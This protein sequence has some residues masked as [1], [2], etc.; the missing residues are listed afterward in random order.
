MK[1]NR[2]V[3]PKKS[4]PGFVYVR[5]WQTA[6]TINQDF[7]NFGP[8]DMGEYLIQ[9][10]QKTDKDLSTLI[11]ISR[12]ALFFLKGDRHK[13]LRK[14]TLKVFGKKNIKQWES[15][16]D[17]TV[18]EY[19]QFLKHQNNPDLVAHYTHPIFAEITKKIL[20][21]E[22][23]DQEQF[24]YW[25]LQLQTLVEPLLPVRELERMNQAYKMLIADT[26]ISPRQNKENPFN[27]ITLIE[28][29]KRAR[30]ENFNETDA[31]AATIVTYGAAINLS[32]TL[33]NIIWHLLNAPA[34]IRALAAQ[35]TWVAANME[36]LIKIGASPKYIHAISKK[37]QNILNTPLKKGD[38][39]LLDLLE[40]HEIGCPFTNQNLWD[41][42]QIQNDTH[43]AFGTGIRFCIGS[44]LTKSVLQKAIPQ[45]FKAFPN[46]KA[47]DAAPKI[48]PLKQTLIIPS[49][50]LKNLN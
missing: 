1:S 30:I 42:N 46:I 37:D 29:L 35:E 38:N 45:I 36:Y 2:I 40:I 34:P 43:M 11:A 32:Q 4:H 33:A 10:Q 20:G 44:I 41:K 48:S 26:K 7:A 27:G 3:H 39:V 22:V 47:R 24:D 23:R 18:T 15:V 9:L 5:D 6:H 8:P 49:I 14:E 12:N 25:T 28:S 19:L 31:F 50:P 13:Q 16:I 21:I 17:K